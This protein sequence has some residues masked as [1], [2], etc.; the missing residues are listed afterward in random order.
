MPFTNQKI[1]VTGTS[2]HLGR[3][4]VGYL[5]QKV[6]VSQVVAMA[7]KKGSVEDLA[8][9]GVEVREADYAKPETLQEVFKG[10]DRLLLVS[11]NAVGQRFAQHRNVIDAAK[12]SGVKL[13]GYTSILHGEASPLGLKDEHVQTEVYLRTAGGPHVLLR[14]GWYTENYLGM[15][16]NVLGL[17]MLYG[18][19]GQGRLATA[20][21]SDYAEAA[22]VIMASAEDQVGKAYELAGDEAYTL[23]DWAA[24]LSRQSGKTVGYKDLP[25]AGYKE[26]LVKAGVPD[27][28]AALLAD[29]DVGASKDGLFDDSHVLSGLVGHPT[30][31]WKVSMAEALKG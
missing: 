26:L 16:H 31:S 19:A 5:L 28:Y 23:S 11:S 3:L 22:A 18:S 21:R 1:M 17:G 6:D 2:G 10:V 8:A 9:L 13:V 27:L 12:R 15:I 25:E 14:N 30:K 24:E 29:S 4:V 7:R 20:A